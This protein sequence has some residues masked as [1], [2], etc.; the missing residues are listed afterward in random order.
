M[1][2]GAPRHLAGA[3][4]TYIDAADDYGVRA[5]ERPEQVNW[6]GYERDARVAGRSMRYVDPGSGEHTVVLVH[7]FSAS[8]R[9]WSDVMPALANQYRVIA[10]DL[11]GFGSSEPSD[12]PTMP[13]AAGAVV[14]LIRQVRSSDAPVTVVGH[15]MGT[16]VA[17][18]IA[19]AAP[20]LV[21]RVVLVGGPCMSA[22]RVVQHPSY[23]F[24]APNLLSVLLEVVL[25]VIPL[26]QAVHRFIARNAW[27]RSVMLRPYAYKPKRIAPEMVANLLHGFGATA[28][29]DVLKE[30]RHYN[31]DLAARAV[32][33][34]IF[35]VHGDKDLLV[36]PSDVEALAAMAPVKKV[37][38]LRQ[39]G[40]NPEIERPN[41]LN[42]VLM[43]LL[44]HEHSSNR[45]AELP[46]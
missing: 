24:K 9:V 45:P 46:R 2:V 32:T 25:G 35:V 3:E 37:F 39:T 17:T 23:V 30:A 19:A 22:V 33:C 44:A 28:N 21:E 41:T 20:E 43:G 27:A 18:E 40:H 38:V 6:S 42:M 5:V 12:T 31:Y 15:S 8:W 4:I 1:L 34:P 13:A 14:E 36:P 10:V 26:P 11:P 16:L 29:H 7:G